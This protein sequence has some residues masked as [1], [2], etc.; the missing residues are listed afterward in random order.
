MRSA[1]LV[2]PL[3]LA[4]SSGP[5]TESATPRGSRDLIT[6]AQIERNVAADAWDL[7][8]R[9]RPEYLRPQRGASSLSAPPLSAVVY[10]DGVKRGTPELLRSLRTSDIEE[11]RFI[12]GTDAT[13]RWGT[14]H[15]GGVIEVKTRR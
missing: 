2:L 7:V 8:Q 12:S 10:L 4:C 1:L 15:G 5:R 14:D 3:L 13:T 6:R 9:L 11:I